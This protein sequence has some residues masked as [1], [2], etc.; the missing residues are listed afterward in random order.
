MYDPSAGQGYVGDDWQNY[1][2][3]KLAAND[4]Q[5]QA[6]A[7]NQPSASMMASMMPGM[8]GMS[9]KQINK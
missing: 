4:P 7:A 5:K 3:D 1:D 2:W 8:E 6:A 9:Q